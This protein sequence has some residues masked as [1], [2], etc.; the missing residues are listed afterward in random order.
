MKRTLERIL[1]MVIEAFIALF[2]YVVGNIAPNLEAQSEKEIIKCSG[3]IVE[4]SI[5]V[6]NSLLVGEQDGSKF[7]VIVDR[8]SVDVVGTV[9]DG[10]AHSKFALKASKGLGAI[11]LQGSA[12]D[13]VM[14]GA[15]KDGLMISIA[16]GGADGSTFGVVANRDSVDVVGTVGEAPAQD[17]FVLKA[18]KGMSTISF[19]SPTQYQ[20]RMGATETGA[21]ISIATGKKLDF[22]N[23]NNVSI[24]TDKEN[25]LILLKD[26]NGLKFFDTITD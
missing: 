13:S 5:I 26:S 21:V 25:S 8:D 10:Q 12:I 17:T 2:G 20:A 7:G 24:K 19:I 18:T 1:F 22:K 9:G 23:S 11:E 4:D 16:N 3:L 6:K 15:A 14:I